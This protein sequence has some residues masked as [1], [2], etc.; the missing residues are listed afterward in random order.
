[1]FK[2][3]FYRRHF[4]GESDWLIDCFLNLIWYE[5]AECVGLT[6]ILLMTF[7]PSSTPRTGTYLDTT[8][9][10]SW[11]RISKLPR[12]Y[13]IDCRLI[14]SDLY[15][16]VMDHW[17]AEENTLVKVAPIWKYDVPN[18][19]WM[20]WQQAI[21]AGVRAPT[22]T[23]TRTVKIVWP[24]PSECMYVYEYV[25]VFVNWSILI[26]RN[27]K[28]IAENHGGRPEPEPRRRD[29][30]SDVWQA[31]ASLCNWTIAMGMDRD[32]FEA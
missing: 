4:N 29:A 20:R 27:D 17:N 6:C 25:C 16:S 26:K 1:M 22:F 24:G 32:R 12:L 8:G 31:N 21:R 15:Y 18:E 14:L 28:Q 30:D 2:F 19:L 23:Y 11:S 7:Q 13:F 5:C 3:T 9:S 10:S